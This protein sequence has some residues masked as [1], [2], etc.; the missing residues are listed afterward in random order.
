M[1]DLIPTYDLPN[2]LAQSDLHGLMLDSI[3]EG[4]CC[5]DTRGDITFLNR[6]AAQMLE[7]EPL[8]LVGESF[9]ETMHHNRL[10]SAPLAPD[11][12]PICRSLRSEQGCFVNHEVFWRPNGTSFPVEYSARPLN[13][14]GV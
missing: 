5:L 13:R 9:H 10:H 6:A 3:A 11:D 12:C 7:V 1:E 14:E 4:V 2:P 8:K